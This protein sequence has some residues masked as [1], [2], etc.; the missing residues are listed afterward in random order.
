MYRSDFYDL[1]SSNNIAT[2]NSIEKL[3]RRIRL[4]FDKPLYN[5]KFENNLINEIKILKSFLRNK[6]K[7]IFLHKLAKKN[8]NLKG[9]YYG[10]NHAYMHKFTK[11][12]LN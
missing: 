2:L 9:K 4:H 3:V 11:K 5:S 7:I 12:S 6:I 8:V 10:F 1:I